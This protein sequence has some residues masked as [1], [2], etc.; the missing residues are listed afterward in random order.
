MESPD[1]PGRFREPVSC[2]VVR[3]FDF[4]RCQVVDGFV[5]ALVVEPVHPVQGLDFDV[6]DVAP[7]PF[8]S[9]QLG[10]VGADLGLGQGV[11]VGV[12]H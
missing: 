6:L 4:G 1:I 2:S 9:D 8:G 3:G 11:V 7:G 10:L 12:A 5:G